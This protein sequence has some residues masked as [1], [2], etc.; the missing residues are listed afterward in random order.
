MKIKQN[1]IIP[2][3]IAPLKGKKISILT[4][5]NTLC[6]G[7]CQGLKETFYV[8]S[9][10]PEEITETDKILPKE[11][12]WR[13][14]T[15]F[16]KGKPITV[17]VYQVHSGWDL[18]DMTNPKKEYVDAE[19][20]LE[21]I[22][23]VYVADDDGSFNYD[24]EDEDNLLENLENIGIFLDYTTYNFLNEK[25]GAKVMNVAYERVKALGAD[26]RNER[27]YTAVVEG[28]G[29]NRESRVKE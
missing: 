14:G 3:K 9:K 26:K 5:N 17:L 15:V 2:Q 8:S 28:L 18:T 12:Q 16:V 25:Y 27:Y 29:K 20:P 6:D 21:D 4:K 11:K 23:A 10:K 22:E 1:E 7:V 24:F 19:E 13:P